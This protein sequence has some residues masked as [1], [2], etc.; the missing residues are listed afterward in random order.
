MFG[1][2]VLALFPYDDF[3]EDNYLFADN[4]NVVQDQESKVACP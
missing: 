4:N 3:G 2:L 1:S